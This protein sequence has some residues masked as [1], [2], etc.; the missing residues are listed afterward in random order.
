MA[1]ACASGILRVQDISST[2]A[3]MHVHSECVRMISMRVHVHVQ[4]LY[5]HLHLYVRI[6]VICEKLCVN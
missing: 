5:D 1:C 2:R 6:Q 4:T 3:R